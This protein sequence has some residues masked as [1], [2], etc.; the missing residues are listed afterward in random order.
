MRAT[1]LFV[2]G[3]SPSG[4]IRMRVKSRNGG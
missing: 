1:E 2:V 4:V 3:T